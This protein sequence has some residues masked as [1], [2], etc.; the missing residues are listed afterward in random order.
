MKKYF[1][2]PLK[3]PYETFQSKV[4]FRENLTQDS[5]KYDKSYVC[6][7]FLTHQNKALVQL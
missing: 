2:F 1:Y 5:F 6:T 7:G 4:H 3:Y